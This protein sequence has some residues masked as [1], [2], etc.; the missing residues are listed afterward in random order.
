MPFRITLPPI[1]A[2]WLVRLGAFIVP[3]ATDQWAIILTP[4]NR[5]SGNLRAIAE[6]AKHQTDARVN[7]ID[8]NSDARNQGSVVA[9]K[10]DYYNAPSLGSVFALLRSKVIFCQSRMPNSVHPGSRIRGRR[11]YLVWHGI[12]F[13]AH[14]RNYWE[15]QGHSY[16]DWILVASSREK[17]RFN[18]QM[19]IPKH[20]LRIVGLPRLDYLV[21]GEKYLPSDILERK[22]YLRSLKQDKKLLLW[23]PSWEIFNLNDRLPS[24]VIDAILKQLPEGWLLGI[25]FHPVR[26][27][28]RPALPNDDRL[29]DLNDNSFPTTESVLREVDVL[30]TDFSSI[31]V[32]FLALD[33]PIVGFGGYIDDIMSSGRIGKGYRSEFPGPWF[34]CPEE[35]CQSL[36]RVHRADS[37]KKERAELLPILGP[38]PDANRRVVDFV[39]RETL[40][41][42]FSEN[43]SP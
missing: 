39:S 17:H 4:G 40:S 8:F 21:Y 20:K 14:N 2:K 41:D 32:D 36:N 24:K 29:L 31:W 42:S 15:K 19:G 18:T 7:V 1:L 12:G 6:A 22:S 35:L 5:W 34:S 25:R 16:F 28:T 23:A 3:P 33:R 26:A 43:Q 9:H 38:Y 37:F 27:S 13:K 11:Y 30:M 10:F